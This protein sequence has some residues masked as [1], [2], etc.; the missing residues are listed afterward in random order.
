MISLKESILGSTR[1]GASNYFTKYLDLIDRV[2]KEETHD[3]S[4]RLENTLILAIYFHSGKGVDF[5][6]YCEKLRDM[7]NLSA[8]DIEGLEDFY[9]WMKT[10]TDGTFN[11]EDDLII[12][13][14]VGD[15]DFKRKLNEIFCN[16]Y[17]YIFVQ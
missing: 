15:S 7:G 9:T 6:K 8:L 1:T 12:K 4:Y 10:N 11:K 2:L 17:E 5:K 16:Y 3:G 13:C 14:K